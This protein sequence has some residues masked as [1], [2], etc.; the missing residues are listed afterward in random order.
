MKQGFIEELKRR[1]QS[2]QDGTKHFFTDSEAEVQGAKEIEA[3]PDYSYLKGKLAEELENLKDRLQSRADHLYQLIDKLETQQTDV[4][5]VL[6]TVK[7]LIEH[8]NDL[9]E[10]G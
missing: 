6:D 3:T 4:D 7:D 9:P 10:K 2:L 5:A 8:I 1:A